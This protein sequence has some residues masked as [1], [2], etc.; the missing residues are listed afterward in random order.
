MFST[1]FPFFHQSAF[2]NGQ[3]ISGE[4]NA[5]QRVTNPF[6]GSVL[7]SVPQLTGAEVQRAITGAEKAQVAW[8]N[9]TADTKAKVLR[10]WYELIEQHHESL[11]TLLTLEQ[12]KPLAESKGEIHYAA[13]FVEWYAEEAKRA[14]G[15]LIPSHKTDA[16]ILVS[17]QPVGV[18]AAITPWNFPAAMIT[19]KCAP[20]FAAGCA[21]VLKP[22]PDT[23]FTALALA[24]LAQQAGIPDGLFQVVT[25]DAIEVGR[26]LT[27][28][29]TVRK[30][31]FTGSTGVGKL[32]M[33][34]SANS[35][36]KLSLEL[37]GNAPFI[38]FEDADINAAID[39]VM[40]AKFRNA[41]QT[42]V[43]A[44]RIYVHDAV[45]DQFAAK[46]VDRVSKLKVG[47]G[48]DEG[49]S[50]GPL[51]NDAAVAKV[52]SHIVDAQ[53]KGAK[54]VFG[55][56][57]QVGSRL[58]EPHVLTEV[59]D[60]MQVASE[61]TFGPLAALFRFSSEQE[62]IERANAT[63]SGLA[64]YCYTQ[65]LRRAWH[66]SEALEAGIV[67]IN[68]GLISTTLA[69]FGGIKESGLGREGAKH[70][71]EEYLEVK[72]TLMGGLA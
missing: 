72:Y 53:S 6:D 47:N 40:V 46:L 69:P 65:S 58:F 14:Y 10:R 20:A 49:V 29:K 63:D 35:V 48:L 50:I 66:M 22:A 43:C 9:Q 1:D 17:R 57:P 68:E 7:G 70:G 4:Q 37:G 23:P 60:D 54:V 26:V 64:A 67:G 34:Q 19:R 5:R 44:N 31:S 62:V 21:V 36:K 41:G 51:I 11:A 61:E 16:R 12:G 28:S 15:E 24:D 71:L 59:T 55:K 30:L 3:W 42:C 27:E 32:L 38:V 18:V 52:T 39:G 13:S 2:I 8:R 33:A 45:Y 56:L 25:G